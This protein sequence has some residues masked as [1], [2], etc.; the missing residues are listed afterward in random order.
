MA[1]TEQPRYPG[2]PV[3]ARYHSGMRLNDCIHM[4]KPVDRFIAELVAVC[5]KHGMS[6][7]HEDTHGNFVI[8]KFD[9]DLVE[10]FNDASVGES[11]PAPEP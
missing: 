8:E 4:N 7:S 1:D 10:W 11:M 5:R 6:I 9:D 2:H 3:G